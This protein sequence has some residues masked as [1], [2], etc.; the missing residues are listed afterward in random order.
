MST[1][2]NKKMDV[3][4]A[5]KRAQSFAEFLPKVPKN[6]PITLYNL[7]GKVWMPFGTS[8]R[9]QYLFEIELSIACEMQVLQRIA[10]GEYLRIGPDD[11]GAEIYVELAERIKKA[12]LEA[13]NDTSDEEADKGGA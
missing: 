6:V 3:S 8:I 4:E 11:P 5:T 13:N 10:E 12:V 9:A 7:Q 1:T 2:I